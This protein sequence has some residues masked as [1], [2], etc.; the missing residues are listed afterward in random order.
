MTAVSDGEVLCNPSEASLL[1]PHTGI[2]LRTLLA[3]AAENY[4]HSHKRT[5]KVVWNNTVI[6]NVRIKDVHLKE[7][8]YIKPE[9][10]RKQNARYANS[11]QDG[12]Q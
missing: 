2:T 8:G 3:V 9:I 5:W 11:S 7:V 1:V 10:E 6:G 4:Q 12:P